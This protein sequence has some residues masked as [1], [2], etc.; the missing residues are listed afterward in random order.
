M[1]GRGGG[2]KRN[3]TMKT[4][5]QIDITNLIS[6]QACLSIFYRHATGFYHKL[7]RDPEILR[8]CHLKVFRSYQN[9][10]LTHSSIYT[11]FN[12]SQKKSCWK[13]LWKKGEIAQN[14]Q[15]HFFST[16]FSRQSVS[17]NLLIATF[18]LSSAASLNMGLSQKGVLGNGLR[19]NICKEKQTHT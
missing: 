12:T 5:G 19:S 3:T 2:G 16:M 14:E 4:R 8:N 18:Q 17:Y 15:F 13:T 11:H 10:V 7:R 9:F 6:D 1:I